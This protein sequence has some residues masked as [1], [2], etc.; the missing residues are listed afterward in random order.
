[1]V[2]KRG[3]GQRRE[4]ESPLPKYID[5]PELRDPAAVRKLFVGVE[6]L[7]AGTD[8]LSHAEEVRLFK[9]LQASAYKLN[10]VT[11]S[12][13]R[14]VAGR[15]KWHGWYI[16][17]FDRI[18]NANIGLVY[19]M[20]RRTRFTSAD[21]EDLLSEGFWALCQALGSFDPWKGYRF[22]T[23]ACTS[24]L[25]RFMLL[26][27]NETRR[28]DRVA[29]DWD[30][31]DQPISIQPVLS[32]DRALLRDRLA[33]ALRGN[34]PDLTPIERFVI[35]QRFFQPNTARKNTLESVGRLIKV[36]KE[37]VRQ[38]QVSALGKIREA[39]VGDPVAATAL[40]LDFAT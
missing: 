31:L 35:E 27:K 21:R 9:V 40:D 36:S 20:R 24:I 39:L 12:G 8:R 26:V 28:K 23:Y 4:G 22:S 34:T 1:M 37:R 13:K 16:R 29:T 15:A 5:N 25:R 19:E 7:L 10:H 30:W 33:M 3:I 11:G 14:V 18:A 32:T 6:D 17:I 38:I 2:K